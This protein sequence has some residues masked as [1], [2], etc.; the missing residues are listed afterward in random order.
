[1][2]STTTRVKRGD[3]LQLLGHTGP[4]A[5]LQLADPTRNISK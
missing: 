2:Q 1:M 5:M 3:V 4:I